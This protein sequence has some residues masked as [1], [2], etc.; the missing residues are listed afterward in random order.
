[1]QQG[2]FPVDHLLPSARVSKSGS[3]WESTALKGRFW[4]GYWRLGGGPTGLPNGG[5]WAFASGVGA[6]VG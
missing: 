2:E 4:E 3:D 5:A 1:M 6:G